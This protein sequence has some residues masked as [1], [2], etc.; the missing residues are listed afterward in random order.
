MSRKENLEPADQMTL[1]ETLK[2]FFDAVGI[3]PPR[4]ADVHV[5]FDHE[6]QTVTGV[7]ITRKGVTGM[8]GRPFSTTH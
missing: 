1:P 8:L 4:D 7:I 3:T 2:D 6:T 5:F